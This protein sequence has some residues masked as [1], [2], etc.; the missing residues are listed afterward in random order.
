[1]L[2]PYV[3]HAPRCNL[4][5]TKLCKVYAHIHMQFTPILAPYRALGVLFILFFSFYFEMNK[6][7]PFCINTVGNLVRCVKTKEKGDKEQMYDVWNVF[8]F[9]PNIFFSLCLLTWLLYKVSASC[10]FVCTHFYKRFLIFFHFKIGSCRVPVPVITFLGKKSRKI[11]WKSGNY[12]DI[13]W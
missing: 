13:C 4:S 5:F 12:F 11:T 8:F 3:N 10:C 9:P 6:K 1:M 7:R 2:K